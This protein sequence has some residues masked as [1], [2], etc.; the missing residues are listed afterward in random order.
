MNTS[1]LKRECWKCN[2][3]Q[4]HNCYCTFSLCLYCK[5]GKGEK[6][7]YFKH[8]FHAH[9]IYLL[10]WSF[11]CRIL[12]F[13]LSHKS[14]CHIYYTLLGLLYHVNKIKLSQNNH[15]SP[16]DQVGPALKKSTQIGAMRPYGSSINRRGTWPILHPYIHKFDLQYKSKKKESEAKEKK[17]K[18][19]GKTKSKFLGISL[20]QVWVFYCFW[21]SCKGQNFF[22]NFKSK[23]FSYKGSK[24]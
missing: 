3:G 14:H 9:F 10:G 2:Y 17:E 11:H 23:I 5:I 22:N 16:P 7:N 4:F 12:G 8:G 24:F 21:E 13:L 20:S 19:Q 1:L 15:L 6:E 18:N